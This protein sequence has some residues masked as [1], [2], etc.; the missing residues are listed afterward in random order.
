MSEDIIDLSI[1]ASVKKIKAIPKTLADISQIAKWSIAYFSSVREQMLAPNPVK[2]APTLT[3]SQI[4]KLC[5]IDKI[6][7][8]NTINKNTLNLPSGSDA[9]GSNIRRFTLAESAEWYEAFM[10]HRARPKGLLAKLICIGNFKG[11]VTKTTTTLTLAQ[12]LALRGRKVLVVDLDPQG[13]LST[14]MGMSINPPVPQEATIMPF[15]YGDEEDL[16]YAPQPSYWHGIDL[17]PA[18]GLVAHTEFEIPSQLAH[19]QTFEFWNVLNK[20]I[21]PLRDKYDVI[22]LDTPPALS[23]LTINALMASDAIV[24]PVPPNGLDYASSVQFLSL[25]ADFNKSFLKNVPSLKDKK[26]DFVNVL[27]TKV[28]NQ[29]QATTVVRDW[30]IGTYKDLVLPA[31]ISLSSGASTSAAQFKTAYDFSTYSG[32]N[33]VYQR[34]RDECEQFASIIDDQL[35]DAWLNDGAKDGD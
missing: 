4:A 19:D 3:L 10:P 21:A 17:I 16:S 18:C 12:G 28:E 20:G 23:F 34:T 9:G 14:L 29:K 22:L 33:K 26:Y 24:I 6:K 2:V 8:N 32:V 25:F 11:G 7:A 27:L 5:E 13:S 15:I 31:E 1:G 35:L 30:I